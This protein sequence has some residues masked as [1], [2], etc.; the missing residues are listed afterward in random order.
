MAGVQT[1]GE[2]GSYYQKIRRTEMAASFHDPAYELLPV[3]EVQEAH[4]QATLAWIGGRPS[5]WSEKG[6]NF[7]SGETMEKSVALI[8]DSRREQSYQGRWELKQGDTILASQEIMGSLGIGQIKFVPLSVPMPGVSTKTDLMLH[9]STNIGTATHAD[10][11]ALR[12][13]PVSL[14]VAVDYTLFDPV[15]KTSAMLGRKTDGPAAQPGK[16]TIIGRE[17]MSHERSVWKT[18]NI[19]RPRLP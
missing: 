9:L 19:S 5:D 11:F 18:M 7:R 16:L 3:A 17:A 10:S 4:H 13:W 12:A 8:N 1:P 15:G 14:S 6:H 2:R